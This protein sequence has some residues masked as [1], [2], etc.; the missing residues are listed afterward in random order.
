[1]RSRGA[2]PRSRHVQ[3]GGRYGQ[4]CCL[5]CLV[6]GWTAQSGTLSLTART[7]F[8]GG[9]IDYLLRWATRDLCIFTLQILAVLPVPLQKRTVGVGFAV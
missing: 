3:E 4:F 7:V 8:R 6:W 1:M 5:V 9:E 2:T